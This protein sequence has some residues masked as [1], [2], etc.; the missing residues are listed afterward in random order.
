MTEELRRNYK[1]EIP[2]DILHVRCIEKLYGDSS[3]DIIE[4]LY[5]FIFLKARGFTQ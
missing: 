1:I 4:G 2:L 3:D 5:L